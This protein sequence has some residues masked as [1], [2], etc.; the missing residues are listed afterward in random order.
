[1][2]SPLGVLW[3]QIRALCRELHIITKL[4]SFPVCVFPSLG[5][6]MHTMQDPTKGNESGTFRLFFSLIGSH[7]G[8]VDATHSSWAGHQAQDLLSLSIYEVA[9]SN[10]IFTRSLVCSVLCPLQG[11][12]ERWVNPALAFPL[13]YVEC[14]CFDS[15]FNTA[16]LVLPSV[17]CSYFSNAHTEYY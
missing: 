7:W 1:M 10:R 9:T 17:S 8:V 15:N 13:Q 16:A 12:C 3:L 6:C 11:E 4:L 2:L 5:P 14:T